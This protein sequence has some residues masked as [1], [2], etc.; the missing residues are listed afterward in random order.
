MDSSSFRLV[1]AGTPRG[2]CFGMGLEIVTSGELSDT[3]VKL[4]SLPWPSLCR[5]ARLEV[6]VGGRV[7]GWAAWRRGGGAFTGGWRGARFA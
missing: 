1:A 5:S 4:G 6:G 3:G 2:L 7:G